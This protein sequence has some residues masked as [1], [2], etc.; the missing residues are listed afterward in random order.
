[1]ALKRSSLHRLVIGADADWMP[2][3]AISIAQASI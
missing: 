3:P 1:V 2:T